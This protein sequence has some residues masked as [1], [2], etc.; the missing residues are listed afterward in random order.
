M[1]RIEDIVFNWGK[2]TVR[3]RKLSLYASLR[4]GAPQVR[5]C[6][7]RLST[8]SASTEEQLVSAVRYL[9]HNG[10]TWSN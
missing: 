2:A 1:K 6:P 10:V 4:W 3:G 8:L 7:Y 9:L 5:P